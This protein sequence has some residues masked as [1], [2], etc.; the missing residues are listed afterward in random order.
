MA[1]NDLI[2]GIAGAGGDG[3][4]SAG[5]LV[6]DI[7]AQQ[8]LFGM[9]FKSFGPQIRGGES[10]IRLRISTEPVL[11]QGDELDVL[12][13]FNWAD[14]ARF[15]TELVPNERTVIFVDEQDKTPEAEIPLP[16]ALKAGVHR[17]AFEDLATEHAG[18]ALAKNIVAVGVLA[19]ALGLPPEGFAA[20]IGRRFAKKGRKVVDGNV[21]AFE[22]GAGLA[23]QYR[24]QG[25]SLVPTRTEP[26]MVIPGNEATGFGALAAGCRFIASYP[27]TPQ[28]EVMEYL[29]RE[30]PKFGGTMV[31]GEDEIASIAMSIGA[32]YAGVKALTAS[33]GP[34]ISLKL[35][36]IGLASIA[37]IPIVIL[38]VQRVGPSTGI[39]TKT[40]QSDLLQGIF[41]THGDAS[42]VVVCTTDVADCFW[43]TVD[44]FNI[45]EEFQTPVLILSDQ[46]IGHR[47]EIVEPFDLSQ[48]RVAERKKPTE[49][50]LAAVDKR[51]G[52][53][54]FAYTADHVSPMSVPGMAGGSY[55]NSGLEHDTI[56]APA[57]GV[58]GHQKMTEKRWKKL[59][60]VAEGYRHLTVIAGDPDAE[61]GIMAWGSC[62]GAVLEAV[63]QLQ[64]QGVKVRA[65]VPRLLWPF[66]L[67]HVEPALEGLTTIHVVELSYSAQFHT[68]LRSQLRAD[69]AGRLVRHSRAGGAPLG[70]NEVVAWVRGAGALAAAD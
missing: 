60:A 38:N 4:V 33:S 41:G 62:K 29:S 54:R 65:V 66:P 49:A 52:F 37:E 47:T 30:L 32:S 55:L 5:E 21:A 8:G 70:A 28:S 13:A 18:T 68:F 36:A 48:L 7:A 27:I 11:S 1:R 57:S 14:F 50:E 17:I 31:Q 25:A 46:F 35:E 6:L 45:A 2:V 39:P 69:L 3:V 15:R 42:K 63:Q 61:I 24:R 51:H 26:M 44:A 10:S 59:D 34:G 12:I 67:Q 20:S 43:V 40:E 16:P 64:A 56:G 22:A 19:G 58:A 9:L 53:A 23:A